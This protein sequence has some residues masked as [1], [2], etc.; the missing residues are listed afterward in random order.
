MRRTELE[1]ELGEGGASLFPQ[2]LFALEMKYDQHHGETNT[3]KSGSVWF[4]KPKGRFQGNRPSF[5]IN[6]L[7][8][9]D[10]LNHLL[11]GFHLPT[12]GGRNR[13]ARAPAE[14]EAT[15][16]SLHSTVM[17]LVWNLLGSTTAGFTPRVL[18]YNCSLCGLCA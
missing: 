3:L 6:P 11:Y 9:P 4:A 10:P 16:D 5:L 7:I 1:H 17:S 13:V 12:S 2:R 18:S 14:L 8:S 15:A